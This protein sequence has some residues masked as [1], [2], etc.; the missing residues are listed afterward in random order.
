MTEAERKSFIAYATSRGPGKRQI[1][2]NAAVLLGVSSTNEADDDDDDDFIAEEKAASLNSSDSDNETDSATSNEGESE[3]ES[4]ASDERD[5]DE[6]ATLESGTSKASPNEGGLICALCLNQ[7]DVVCKEEVIQCDRCGLAVHENCYMVDNTEDSDS[8]LSSAMTE[9]WF[10][11]PCLYGL[12]SPP[13]CEL[14]PSRYGAFKRSDIGGGW[15]H[16]LCA[17]YTPGITFG[18]VDH[19]T[20]VSWQEA[21]YKL[22]GRKP[23]VVC[24]DSLAARTGIT[25]SCD[26]ALCK[27]SLHVTCAQRLGLLVDNSEVE[28]GQSGRGESAANKQKWYFADAE[29]VDP[30]FLTCQRHSN[31]DIAPRHRQACAKFYKQEEERMLLFHRRALTSR[32]EKKRLRMLAKHKKLLRNLV[33]ISI[34]WPEHDSKRPRLLNT[35]AMFVDL[36]REKAAAVGV[37]GEE[38]ERSFKQVDGAEL[39]FLSPGFSHEFVSY[40]EARENKVFPKEQSRVKELEAEA[41]ELRKQQSILE[42]ELAV[43]G[44]TVGRMMQIPSSREHLVLQDWYDTMVALGVKKI[45]KPTALSCDS[46]SKQRLPRTP[47]GRASTSTA[48]SNATSVPVERNRRASGGSTLDDSKAS[49]IIERTTPPVCSICHKSADQHLLVLCDVCKK[50]YH[51]ACLD[52]PLS[53]M[54]KKSRNCGW[55]CSMC[56][57]ESDDDEEQSDDEHS[58]NESEGNQSAR[59]LRDRT[60][61]SVKRKEEEKA[62]QRAYRSVM[63]AQRR[64]PIRRRG[65]GKTLARGTVTVPLS[66][67]VGEGGGDD[68]ASASF[69][70]VPGSPSSH[71][72]SSPIQKRSRISLKNT[73][74][75]RLNGSLLKINGVRKNTAEMVL[76]KSDIGS[77]GM[78]KDAKRTDLSVRMKRSGTLPPDTESCKITDK[79]RFTN[80]LLAVISPR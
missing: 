42:K 33:G 26:A 9:P 40:L 69:R 51:L 22:F 30:R 77:V 14:C 35:S 70:K 67:D 21:D 29:T 53:K 16:L 80:G 13:Y 65:C 74:V 36:F 15:V 44:K 41:V 56:A 55:E 45:K 43:I 52:P 10:C 79:E 61:M 3:S 34:A 25:V 73:V 6:R 48:R 39:Q 78:T 64:P 60:A 38:F 27:A 2:P 50:H 12:K 63:A 28:K 54:P 17:L 49:V 62:L 7:R 75:Q 66:I 59:K 19:L 18:D 37:S 76:R 23:C 5:D 4:G 8:T 71:S 20:A 47:F 1:K 24:K 72:P 31:P 57:E 11:E 32:E 68:G 46:S 58:L